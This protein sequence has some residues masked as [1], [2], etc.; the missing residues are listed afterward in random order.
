MTRK[1]VVMW[2][3]GPWTKNECCGRRPVA[4]YSKPKRVCCWKNSLW[5]VWLVSYQ[6][7]D[8]T[9]RISYGE[10]DGGGH[11]RRILRTVPKLWKQDCFW[12]V[13]FSVLYRRTVLKKPGRFA[14]ILRVE[15]LAKKEINKKQT[16]RR[17]SILLDL[18]DG[19]SEFLRTLRCYNQGNLILHNH[20]CQNFKNKIIN[21]LFL[22]WK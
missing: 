6:L 1:K 18:V 10:K 17:P 4:I 19:M 20:C 2:S 5:Q 15:R 7:Q 8:V 21:L 13:W 9:T 3:A 14:S 16:A 12:R 11:A 22:F